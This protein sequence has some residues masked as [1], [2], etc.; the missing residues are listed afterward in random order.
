MI[1][2]E[3]LVSFTVPM[4]GQTG[5]FCNFPRSDSWEVLWWTFSAIAEFELAILRRQPATHSPL[6]NPQS[7]TGLLIKTIVELLLHSAI[8]SLSVVNTCLLSYPREKSCNNCNIKILPELLVSHYGLRISC[9]GLPCNINFAW[10]FRI[11]CN[12]KCASFLSS[13]HI[14]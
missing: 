7:L 12:L 14:L 13:D 6:S 10:F 3:R 5:N 2:G 8:G 9:V 11:T 1:A 4:S